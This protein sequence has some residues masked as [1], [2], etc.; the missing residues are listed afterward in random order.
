M[1]IFKTILGVLLIVALSVTATALISRATD[2]FN[3]G[4]TSI[5]YNDDNLVRT[6]EEY[7]SKEGNSGNGITWTIKNGGAVVADGTLASDEDEAIFRL[8]FVEIKEEGFYT[9]SGAPKNTSSSTYYIRASYEDVSGTNNVLYANY[10]DSMTSVNKIP[11][12]TVVTI[13]IV[14]V[15]GVSVENVKFTPTFVLGTEAGA[16]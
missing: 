1:K 16:F 3:S 5:F 7:V 9:L 6:L 14:I 4:I 12:G 15:P 13:E 2:G 11:A 10:S 8:G